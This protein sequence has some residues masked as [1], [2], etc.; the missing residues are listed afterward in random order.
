MENDCDGCDAQFAVKRQCAG[1]AGKPVTRV[2]HSSP[3]LRE[4]P[5]DGRYHRGEA[6]A[7]STAPRRAVFLP[8]ATPA[9]SGVLPLPPPAS[10][11]GEA[12]ARW[13]LEDRGFEIQGM[14]DAVSGKNELKGVELLWVL[15]A[16]RLL[17][18]EGDGGM[19][20][21]Q[22]TQFLDSK[23]YEPLSKGPNGVDS[24]PPEHL[25]ELFLWL[26]SSRGVR[27]ALAQSAHADAVVK[28]M[29]SSLSGGHKNAKVV[30]TIVA[31][32]VLML[33]YHR[34][35]EA[36]L[37]ETNTLQFLR[38]FTSRALNGSSSEEGREAGREAAACRCALSRM[39]RSPHVRGEGRHADAVY[40]ELTAFVA[41][42][43]KRLPGASAAARRTAMQIL[44]DLLALPPAGAPAAHAAFHTYMATLVMEASGLD[45]VLGCV[46]A[47]D[48][49]TAVAAAALLGAALAAAGSEQ[50]RPPTE[51]CTKIMLRGARELEGLLPGLEERLAAAR[52][53]GERRP[54]G[55]L[56]ASAC[57]NA[58]AN[59]VNAICG[60]A[61]G[62]STPEKEPSRTGSG[63]CLEDAAVAMELE[64]CTGLL[65]AQ[66][67]LTLVKDCAHRGHEAVS[68]AALELLPQVARAT[69]LVLAE[70]LSL[71]PPLSP[72]SPGSALAAGYRRS[73]TDGFSILKS[74]ADSHRA[75]RREAEAAA[76]EATAARGDLCGR[77][78]RLAAWP[79]CVDDDAVRAWLS[80]LM[81]R[82]CLPADAAQSSSGSPCPAPGASQAEAEAGVGAAESDSYNDNDATLVMSQDMSTDERDMSMGGSP[83]G[84]PAQKY[85]S[86]Y[87]S[88]EIELASGRKSVSQA[89]GAL[90]VR[91]GGSPALDASSG[92]EE[93]PRRSD[94][95]ERASLLLPESPIMAVSACVVTSSALEDWID[96][97]SESVLGQQ[98]PSATQRDGDGAYFADS[99]GE[100]A[101]AEEAP[102][103]PAGAGAARLEAS[104]GGSIGGGEQAGAEL[105]A[106]SAALADTIASRDTTIQALLAK[107]AVYQT[108]CA[109]STSD[110]SE[111]R[112]ALCL[113][114]VKYDSSVQKCDCQQGLIEESWTKLSALA[115]DLERSKE[116]AAQRRAESE[117]ATAH[118]AAVECR[119][120]ECRASEAEA[121]SLA[122]SSLRRV[123][124]CIGQ[125]RR[126]A[127]Q[128]ARVE[129][130]RRA[131]ERALADSEKGAE[132]LAAVVSLQKGEISSIKS[133]LGNLSTEHAALQEARDHLQ[134]ENLAITEE[135][136]EVLRSLEDKVGDI[137][138]LEAKLLVEKEHSTSVSDQLSKREA[139]V[140][141]LNEQLDASKEES[142]S[143]S[144]A[145]QE[146]CAETGRVGALLEEAQRA[147]AEA[148]VELA[149]QKEVFMYINK[150]S[151]EKLCAELGAPPPS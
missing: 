151:A 139:E 78:G 91:G 1:S 36:V 4:S 46:G 56:S 70:T 81:P 86:S 8:L 144:H 41:K 77:L 42:W 108:S 118:A 72:P 136:A 14:S 44:C 61:R 84:S 33:D 25:W 125:N 17:E 88:P 150:L 93:T 97:E 113:L 99:D 82:A 37:T 35:A 127:E 102:T 92:G 133:Q 135:K 124:D 53:G 145:L 11:S 85:A 68:A 129:G 138:C 128:K 12:V 48:C 111:M 59:V 100:Q 39:L 32:V 148:R 13:L 10:G 18:G 21:P 132:E 96:Q 69:A 105:C 16:A 67:L 45:L 130:A 120:L 114:T 55:E 62:R 90:S 38:L 24:I 74:L 110:A 101:E 23:I 60:S 26:A 94:G 65:R 140:A 29:F 34:S 52:A 95:S 119:L 115:K 79:A 87:G 71:R 142:L 50:S 27:Q 6:E 107:I 20:V 54:L 83:A 106:E 143:V 2:T 121:R 58:N 66:C 73:I 3:R 63:V 9:L 116:D 5:A 147:L 126:L 51:A 80:E 75:A 30:T 43:W 15:A 64:N 98:S 7:G 149:K 122:D 28:S 49:D 19:L 123:S 57:T 89:F 146:Q 134:S 141:C 137:G 76:L 103:P 22:F 112:A 104:R 40:R 131:A 117:A 109:A 31:C 47:D